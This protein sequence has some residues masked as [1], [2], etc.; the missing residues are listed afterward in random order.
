MQRFE[1]SDRLDILVRQLHFCR[2][3]LPQA[4]KVSAIRACAKPRLQKP[5]GRQAFRHAG[6][7]PRSAGGASLETE[8]PV[9]KEELSRDEIGIL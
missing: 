7:K 8:T 5:C 2:D 3:C 9:H 6:V 4:G 1:K